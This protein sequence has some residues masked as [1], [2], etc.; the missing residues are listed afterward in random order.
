L[1][2]VGLDK[3]SAHQ[4]SLLHDLRA[5]YGSTPIMVVGNSLS[6]DDLE[7]CRQYAVHEAIEMPRRASELKSAV[8]SIM[9][10]YLQCA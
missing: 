4:F 10:Q 1:I 5:E 7:H 2:T 9:Q 6:H 8:F 3:D